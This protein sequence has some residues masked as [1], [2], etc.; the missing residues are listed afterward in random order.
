MSDAQKCMWAVRYIIA[1]T[2]HGVWFSNENLLIEGSS[3][4]AYI[5]LV[6]QKFRAASSSCEEG[7]QVIFQ[8]L[9]MKRV[10]CAT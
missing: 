3:G 2:D 1:A 10:I 9:D 4:C 5:D 7:E 6:L 8:V